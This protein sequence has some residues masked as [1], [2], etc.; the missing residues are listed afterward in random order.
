MKWLLF[1]LLIDRVQY[2][3]AARN[4]RSTYSG[5]GAVDSVLARKALAPMAYRVLVPW[6][7]WLG[8]RV[9]PAETRKVVL[10][11]PLKIALLWACLW[12]ASWVLGETAALVLGLLWLATL[13]FDYW[14]WAVETLALILALSGALPAA[15][16]GAALLALSR[17][18]APLVA[19]TYGFATGDWR[20]AALVLALAL[21]L[22]ALVRLWAGRKK[23]YC[24]RW[25]WR[26]NW[27]E[28]KAAMR[29]QPVY[30]NNM[31]M[32]VLVTVLTLWAVAQGLPAWPVPLAL[33]AAGWSMAVAAET[34]VFA[35]CLI[36]VAMGLS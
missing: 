36:W 26:R 5:L 17:E 35:G 7:V 30:L 20:G 12:A 14:D 16:V 10:Y 4:Y 8:E 23:L 32:T 6:L 28:L 9:V 15:L 29:V 3:V 13:L 31:A 25:M 19:V 24:E 21:A 27:R 2:I 22:M 34:R 11:E 1:A 33:L 18:T